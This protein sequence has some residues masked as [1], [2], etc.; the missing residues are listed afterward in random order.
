MKRW[1]VVLSAVLLAGP[2]WADVGAHEEKQ[3]STTVTKA[4]A[5]LRPASSSNVHGVVTFTKV[6]GGVRVVAD[7]EG[8][9][10]GEHGFHVH[11]FGDCS[12]A[13]AASAG[14]HFNPHGMPHADPATAHRHDGDLGNIVADDSGKAHYD[15]VNKLIALNGADS[16]VGRAVIVHEKA[17]DLKS[18]PTGNAGAR[19]ACGVIGVVKP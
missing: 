7:I 15:V 14:G 10:P 12:A 11:E 5:V 13:S 4:V 2:F 16:V 17:D 8:L 1:L 18:Q 6:E 9:T 3:S 19:V